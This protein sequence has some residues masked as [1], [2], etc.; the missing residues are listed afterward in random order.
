MIKIEYIIPQ[1]IDNLY[2]FP[3]NTNSILKLHMLSASTDY[4]AEERE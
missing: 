3:L 4:Y 1:A 2:C